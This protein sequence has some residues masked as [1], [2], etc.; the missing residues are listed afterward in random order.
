L[1]QTAVT[2]LISRATSLI[3]RSDRSRDRTTT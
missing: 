1:T 2:L 3:D